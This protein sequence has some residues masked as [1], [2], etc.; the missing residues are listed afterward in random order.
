MNRLLY[1]FPF[2]FLAPCYKRNV[3]W[4]LRVILDATRAPENNRCGNAYFQN[5]EWRTGQRTEKSASL[6]QQQQNL[7]LRVSVSPCR[8]HEDLRCS[9]LKYIPFEEYIYR[10]YIEEYTSYVK[11]QYNILSVLYPCIFLNYYFTSHTHTMWQLHFQQCGE[12]RPVLL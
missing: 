11:L 3:R 7:F 2:A 6:E 10:I 4:Y 8:R 1:S 9:Q 12:H 5:V